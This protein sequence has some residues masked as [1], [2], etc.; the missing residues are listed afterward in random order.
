[1]F[2]SKLSIR[3]MIICT[4]QN[5]IANFS[6]QQDLSCSDLPYLSSVRHQRQRAELLQGSLRPL[7]GL[8]NKSLDLGLVLLN[9]RRLPFEPDTMQRSSQCPDQTRYSGF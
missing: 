5:Y 2:V 9:L 3:F 7:H 6:S 4:K 1:M 8:A